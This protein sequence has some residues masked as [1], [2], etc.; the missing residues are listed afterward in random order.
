VLDNEAVGHLS[1]Q[2]S[3]VLPGE[4]VIENPVSGERIVIRATAAQTGGDLLA[5]E[6]FLAPGGRV[7]SSHA[8]PQ[9]EERFTVVDG[10]LRFRVGGRRSTLRP[11]ESV[12]VSPGRVHSFAN[13]GRRTVHVL[14][15]TRPALGMQALLETAAAMAAET[16]RRSWLLPSVPRPHELVL[17]MRDFQGEVR[18]PYL[19]AAVVRAVIGPL[20]WLV[21]RC[22]ADQRY[23]RWRQ[24]AGLSWPDRRPTAISSPERRPT[25]ISSPDRRPAA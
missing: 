16:Q 19:P 20:A 3:T 5:W 7:P 25:A 4:R 24:R 23:R 17:F 11:G 9:Q 15:E 10:V 6:L 14:V 8:H 1:G 18:A 12:R 21:R 22:G 2:E 13:P